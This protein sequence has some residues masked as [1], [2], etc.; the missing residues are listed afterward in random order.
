MWILG[1]FFD[2]RNGG[3]N[4]IGIL[5]LG[6]LVVCLGFIFCILVFLVCLLG[7]LESVV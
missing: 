6:K 2:L 4:L 5:G 3:I 7:F 1:G